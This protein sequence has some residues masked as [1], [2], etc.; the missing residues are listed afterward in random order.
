MNQV[1]Q[2][3][4]S[5]NSSQLAALRA[6]QRSLARATES[7]LF[8]ELAGLVHPDVINRFCDLVTKVEQ[9][10]RGGTTLTSWTVLHGNGL[11]FTCEAEDIHHAI[12][13]CENAYP[14]EYIITAF[15]GANESKV[16]VEHWDSR[17][18][19]GEGAHGAGGISFV[20]GTLDR[21]ETSGQLDVTMGQMEG[22]VDDLLYAM[23]EVNRLPGSKD[24]TQCLHIHFDSENLAMS[25]F[26]QGNKFILRP[27]NGVTVLNTTLPTGQQALIV[28]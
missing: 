26:K 15:E 23:F 13:Q 20:V 6:I 10:N 8:D 4:M 21:R 16:E 2:A 3:E 12:E 1:T 7:S 14:G 24:D 17:C 9:E 25:V 11:H 5:L 22:D 27:E 19:G 18:Y 28:Q